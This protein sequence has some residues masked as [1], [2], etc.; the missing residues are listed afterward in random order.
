MFY[1][2]VLF[3]AVEKVVA[4]PVSKYIL[5]GSIDVLH[6]RIPRSI[7]TDLYFQKREYLATG[8]FLVHLTIFIS[9]YL[10]PQ[11]KDYPK[12]G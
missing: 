6:F 10:S 11:R 3:C 1:P 9:Q 7:W 4:G 2:S 8:I 5:M 12:A